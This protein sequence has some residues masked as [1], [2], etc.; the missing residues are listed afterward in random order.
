M[1]QRLDRSIICWALLTAAPPPL[2]LRRRPQVAVTWSLPVRYNASTTDRIAVYLAPIA[3]TFKTML[4]IK[5]RLT[6]GNGTGTVT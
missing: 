3:S 2:P 5:H 6:D 1:Y 4:P